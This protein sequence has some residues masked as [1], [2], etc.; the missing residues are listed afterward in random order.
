MDVLDI[1]A[2]ILAAAGGGGGL[3]L[4][5]NKLRNGNGKQP[6][7]DTLKVLVSAVNDLKTA[8]Q[9]DSGPS[10]AWQER[11]EALERRMET[12]HADAL[13]YLQKASAAEQRMRARQ[14]VDDD[15]EPTLTPEEAQKLLDAERN[16]GDHSSGPLTLAE[17]ERLAERE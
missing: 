4:A 16:Q 3:T 17:L 2:I 12:V 1:V 7:P 11:V 13:K 15:D 9:R 14:P 10:E 5:V 8:S 6:N